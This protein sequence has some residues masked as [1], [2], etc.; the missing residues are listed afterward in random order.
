[1]RGMPATGACT[2]MSTVSARCPAPSATRARK[3]QTT[4]GPSLRSRPDASD[5]LGSAA[6]LAANDGAWRRHRRE[7][8]EAVNHGAVRSR[9]ARVV[10]GRCRGLTDWSRLA[11]CSR[12]SS[13]TAC[14]R[15]SS[16]A[17]TRGRTGETDATWW[18]SEVAVGHTIASAMA[19]SDTV[20]SRS[21]VGPSAARTRPTRVM[22]RAKI[23]VSAV[24]RASR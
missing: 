15:R 7:R 18:A 10:S 2:G 11:M 1:M 9:S 6:V 19:R 5:D 12:R 16:C 22:S 20:P 24:S 14:G 21:L 3:R 23:S 4:P 13:R 8:R 17:T